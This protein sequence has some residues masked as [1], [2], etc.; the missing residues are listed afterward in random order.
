MDADLD[1]LA[2]HE[3]NLAALEARGRVDP[4]DAEATRLANVGKRLSN[5]YRV[6]GQKPAPMAT[7]IEPASTFGEAFGVGE[8]GAG[9]EHEQ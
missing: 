5:R 6:R 8:G 4:A 9:D 1:W 3:S 2:Q 7:D